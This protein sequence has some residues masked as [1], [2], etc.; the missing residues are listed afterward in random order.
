MAATTGDRL[1]AKATSAALLT[2]LVLLLQ[3][4]ASCSLID[5]DLA[6]CGADHTLNYELQLVTNMTTELQTQLTAETDVQL[7]SQ[8]R[9][10]LADI[11][12]DH[13]HDVDLS[14]YDTQGD[15]AL[16]HHEEHIMN[17]N[18]SSYTLYIPRRAYMHTALANLQD[19]GPVRMEGDE[20]CHTQRLTAALADT[21]AP[22]ATGLFTAREPMTMLEG[23]SQTFNVH[24]YM[25]NCAA[26]LVIDP[27]G[28]DASSLQVYTA[29]FATQFDVADSV[30][31]FPSTSPVFATRQLG[32][33]EQLCFCSVTFPSREP[34][35]A[36]RTV[37]ETTEPF[38]AQPGDE[39]LWEFRA[40][41][42]QPDG[43]TTETR[44][45]LREPLR[46]GQLKIVKAWIDD[47]GALMPTDQTMGVSVILNWN[48]N[49]HHEIE[50]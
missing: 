34:R 16:L 15:S 3:M 47:R 29:G 31:R 4:L 14:F 49:L 33:A 18:Q 50:L 45:A 26:A 43:S 32:D 2:A 22:Q 1:V 20:R 12:T 37:I 19:N 25:A 21:I 44:I 13:A 23:V 9:T 35:A 36:T 17:A 7:S 38:V 6:D 11:F 28:R 42:R 48:E 39:E 46:A 24:L 30:Y 10:E 5:D 8:L 27:R 41:V 40:Y